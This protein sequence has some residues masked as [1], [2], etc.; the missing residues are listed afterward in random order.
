MSP[1]KAWF[2]TARK[3]KQFTCIEKSK[4][5]ESNDEFIVQVSADLMHDLYCYWCLNIVWIDIS[6]LK[7][8][9]L[10]DTKQISYTSLFPRHSTAHL[11]NVLQ[12]IASCARHLRRMRWDFFLHFVFS[13]NANSSSMLSSRLSKCVITRS[14]HSYKLI[15]LYYC[16]NLWSHIRNGKKKLLRF[17]CR[18]FLA[19]CKSSD[20]EMSEIK[21]ALFFDEK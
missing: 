19:D 15:R 1:V 5:R 13:W 14:C 3:P 16:R 11:I 10:D 7:L 21:K 9:F 18:C 12:S 2:R 17:V 8:S 20:L 6:F 4:K